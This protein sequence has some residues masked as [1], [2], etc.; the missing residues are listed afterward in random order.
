MNFVFG[1]GEF[2]VFWYCCWCQYAYFSPFI[3]RP[4]SVESRIEPWDLRQHRKTHQFLGPCCLCPKV[5]PNQPD[6][7]E[8]AIFP[9]P[10][11]VI[12]GE[13][14]ATCARNRCGYFGTY[15]IDFEGNASAHL[16]TQFSWKGFSKSWDSHSRIILAV[17]SCLPCCICEIIIQFLNRCRQKSSPRCD[18][19]CRELH[20]Y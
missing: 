5:D 15:T 6:F 17:V 8:A 16:S 13:Y 7:V 14:I 10:R 4:S 18:S 20:S 19:H 12:S 3:S 1:N 2:R 11:G 9:V